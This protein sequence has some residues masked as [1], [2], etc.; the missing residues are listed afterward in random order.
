VLQGTSLTI[1]VTLAEAETLRRYFQSC[2]ERV[3]GLSVHVALR[4][5]IVLDSSS[6]GMHST[7]PVVHRVSLR[8]LDGLLWYTPKELEALLGQVR[9]PAAWFRP[10]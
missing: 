4:E 7:I 6:R 1:A 5:G 2:Y 3:A 8:F 9:S 10:F